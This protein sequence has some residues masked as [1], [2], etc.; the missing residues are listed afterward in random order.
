MGDGCYTADGVR[1]RIIPGT[2]STQNSSKSQL[3]Q[4]RP[5]MSGDGQPSSSQSA[6]GVRQGISIR[7]DGLSPIPARKTPHYLCSLNPYFIDFLCCFL[8]HAAC[9]HQSTSTA[10]QQQQQRCRGRHRHSAASRQKHQTT[11]DA[12][13]GLGKRSPPVSSELLP[14]FF[15]CN[16][17]DK[18]AASALKGKCKTA[19]ARSP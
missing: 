1:S 3:R 7:L 2:S 6:K 19:S 5:K 17:G 18:Q 9:Q 13:L 11:M 8:L 15:R 12:F 4:Q 10:Q 14:S 16:P